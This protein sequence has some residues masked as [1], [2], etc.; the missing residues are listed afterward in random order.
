MSSAAAATREQRFIVLLLE[1][2]Q[3]ILS[4]LLFVV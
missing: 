3:D 2:N 1:I 4:C